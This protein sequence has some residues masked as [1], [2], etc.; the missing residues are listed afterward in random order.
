MT[1]NR[2]FFVL[3]LGLTLAGCG[4]L[5][6]LPGQGPGADLYDLRGAVPPFVTS[7]A[8]PLLVQVVVAEPVADRSLDT[9]RIAIQP[10]QRRIDY[11][12]AAKW[13]DRAPALIQSLL[14]ASLQHAGRLPGSSRPGGLSAQVSLGGDL[15]NFEVYGTDQPE[16][17]IALRLRLVAQPSGKLIDSRLFQQSAP[18]SGRDVAAV[19]AA[20]EAA[21]R[22]ILHDAADWTIER[23]E[24]LAP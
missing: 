22:P 11:F 21:L 20:F 7:S 1:L 16:V 12:A 8:K 6:D 18:A 2:R 9:D 24:G 3:G 15:E 17:K 14:L 13:S 23:L 10:G 19:T 5:V 4:N